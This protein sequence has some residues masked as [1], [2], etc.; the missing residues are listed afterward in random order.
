MVMFMR[1]YYLFVVNMQYYSLYQ[2]NPDSLYEIL[3]ELF[4]LKSEHYQYGLSIFK[5]ICEPIQVSFLEQYLKSKYE[6]KAFIRK[7]TFSLKNLKIQ[8]R[9]SCI[10]I[11]SKYNL[12]KILQLFYYYN[13]CIFVCD[14]QNQDYFWLERIRIR[15][16]ISYI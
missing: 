15:D 6:E 11:S 14:F 8:L 7:H 9:P 12:P 13:P 3:S 1:T 5:Q 2:R 16:M 4:T 10:K